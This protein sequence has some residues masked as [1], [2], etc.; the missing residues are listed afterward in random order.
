MIARSALRPVIA[1][2]LLMAVAPVACTAPGDEPTAATPD[3]VAAGLLPAVVLEG[4]APA[5]YTLQER[6]ERYH[7]PGVSVAVMD[8]GRIVWARGW[9]VADR[10]TGRPVEPT[11]LFQAAS[12]SKPVAAL[13]AM[14]FVE[15]GRVALDAPV[16]DYMTS[17]RVPDNEFTT[18]SVVTLRGL[19]SHTAGLTVWGFPGYRK[20]EP[21]G[22]A[23]IASNVE[24]LDGLGNTPAVRVYKE[25]GISWQYSGG[26]YTVMEQMLEDLSG[27]PFD[28]VVRQRVLD[29]AGLRI[30]TYAQPLPE[31]RWDEAA[32]GY[33]A[34][35]TEVEGE[36]HNYPEQAAAGLWT[37]PAELLTLSSHLRAV[38]ADPAT[39][40]VVSAETLAEMFAPH[41]E[42]EEGF[43]SY[44]LGFGIG[45]E[46]D[47]I[48]FGH[49]GSNEG[50]KAQWVVYRDRGDG[51]A[52][53][54]NG[55]QGSAL[56][57]EILRSISRAYEWP[58][59]KPAIRTAR[60]PSAE[61]LADF[62]GRYVMEGG[63]IEARV[64]AAEGTLE[65]D[66]PGQGT[67]TLHA[68]AEAPDSFFDLE[69]G[70]SI[71]FERDGK[72]E[73]VALVAGGQTRLQRVGASP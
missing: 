41:R 45:R 14:T 10:E 64:R 66:V 33:R 21:F 1:G 62:Q 37:T 4:E 38:L 44:G 27:L 3:D 7:V 9:G 42:G 68:D 15:E 58:G 56:A 69:D 49:G 54:T 40:G 13:A 63:E 60:F 18:D 61:E 19:L 32:R 35:G 48:T 67:F 5:P 72:G 65:V 39:D 28:E 53:M 50:F 25:P 26:G 31:S 12:I 29:P 43:N 34:D 36:W 57:A 16:N 73:V 71:V 47:D 24:V 23:P 52:V 70:Q 46:G 20:D 51:A 2:S 59:Y 6:M 8:D 55:D 11:T 22:D 30:S 17:W